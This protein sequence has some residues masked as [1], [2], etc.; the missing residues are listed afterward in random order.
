MHRVREWA[1]ACPRPLPAESRAEARGRRGRPPDAA[2]R[3]DGE[4]PPPSRAKRRASGCG[5]RAVARA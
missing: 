4:E 2:P 5:R 1:A 3:V